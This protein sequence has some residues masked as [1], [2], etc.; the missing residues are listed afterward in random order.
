[1]KIKKE[2]IYISLINNKKYEI[3]D[4]DSS[5]KR[6]SKNFK[7]GN[8]YYLKTK[9][10]YVLLTLTF[11]LIIYK[12][13][14]HNPLFFNIKK[15]FIPNTY[16]IAFIFGTRPEAVKLFPLIKELKEN[17]NYVC[18]IINT[19][20]HKE[21]IQQIL[22]SLHM[23]SS[24]DFNLNLMKKNQSL[25]KLTS[26]VILELDKIYNLINPN[27]IIVQGDTTTAFSAALSAYY[28]KIP[29]FHVEAGLRTH[30]LYY[31]FPEEFNRLTIDDL[32]TLYFS[33][34]NWSASNLLKEYKNASNIFVTGNT[35][36]DSL[37]FTLK[38]T[39]PSKNIKS[40]FNKA[41][42]LCLVCKL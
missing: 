27:A 4:N 37:L 24:I 12:Y 13:L 14:I 42:N 34:T 39:S 33:P 29:I 25:A 3:I 41:K 18:I 28:K 16:R 35:I 21:M 22:N 5:F 30:N 2:N 6:H 8:K 17:K 36:V 9:I 19:G 26:T 15:Y 31:P 10:I 38:N 23:E 1:M 40:L 20:Q 7:K 11:S 32:S